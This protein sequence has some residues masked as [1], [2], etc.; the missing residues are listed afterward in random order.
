[1]RKHISVQLHPNTTSY[2]WL[3]A[4]Y[5]DMYQR[6]NKPSPA[7]ADDGA[8]E[9]TVEDANG[10]KIFDSVDMP[11]VSN[12]YYATSLTGTDQI[13]EG[14][15]YLVTITFKTGNHPDWSM[16]KKVIATDVTK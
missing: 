6:I 12:G 10:D 11:Y 14:R 9:V 15:E 1:M 13:I 4:L 5:S 7:Y 3:Q 8:A 16:Y 2:V